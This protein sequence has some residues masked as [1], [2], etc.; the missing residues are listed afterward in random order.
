MY[1][2]TLADITLRQKRYDDA[3]EPLTIAAEHTGDKDSRV[4]LTYLLAQA[5]KAAGDNALS[6]RYFRQVMRM[7]PHMSLSSMRASTLPE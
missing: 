3:V 6:T 2:S 5:C 1:Y 4:R 7:N